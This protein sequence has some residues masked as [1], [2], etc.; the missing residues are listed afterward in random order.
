MALAVAQR[1]EAAVARLVVELQR[2]HVGVLGLAPEV[3]AREGHALVAAVEGADHEPVDGVRHER[4]QAPAPPHGAVEEQQHEP[5]HEEV[6]RVP[7]GLVV[8][9]LHL[10]VR[11]RI[12]H[13]HH[14]AKHLPGEAGGDDFVLAGRHPR[15]CHVRRRAVIHAAGECLRVK[16]RRGVVAVVCEGVADHRGEDEILGARLVEDDVLVERQ[17]VRDP[18]EVPRRSERRDV[19]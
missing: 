3:D 11:A 18:L 6:V 8:R 10:V 12:D 13:E 5:R 15:P 9:A 7:K 19:V 4:R 2:D 1:L 17:H 14:E 16:G